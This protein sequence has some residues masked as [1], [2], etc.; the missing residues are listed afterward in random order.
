MSTFH[1]PG[2]TRAG[3]LVTVRF[4]TSFQ[5]QHF[6]LLG[7]GVEDWWRGC[8]W[9]YGEGS[10][11]PLWDTPLGDGVLIFTDCFQLIPL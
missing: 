3:D 1:L 8:T 7:V 2:K 6:S 10:I 5:L 11:A 4:F 9:S